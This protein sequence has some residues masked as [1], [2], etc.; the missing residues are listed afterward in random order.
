MSSG[1]KRRGPVVIGIGNA[2]QGDD[3]AGL[4]T[5]RRLRGRVPDGVEVV[6]LEGEPVTLVD[7]W[8]DAEVAVLIDAVSSGAVPGT[9]HRRDVT[10]APLPRELS[11]ASTHTFGVGEAVELARALGRLPSRLVV[12]GIEARSLSAG[13]DLSPEV[14]AA[15]A[16]VE[17]RILSE[18]RGE[19]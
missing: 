5:A 4:V 2:W 6:E 15:V 14:A 8:A 1:S 12:Y 18:L 11:T 16:Q 17:E 3:A 7:A 10:E 19:D 13:Q 9:V